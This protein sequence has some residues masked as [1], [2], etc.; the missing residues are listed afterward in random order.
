L[1]ILAT[2]YSIP[3]TYTTLFLSMRST[4]VP[5]KFCELSRKDYIRAKLQRHCTWTRQ[6]SV[7]TQARFIESAAT[8]G[9]CQETYAWTTTLSRRD[10]KS[11]RLNSSHQNI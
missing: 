10:R 6:L 5:A 8:S 9:M 11:T 7:I 2:L 3:L 1:F 4:T